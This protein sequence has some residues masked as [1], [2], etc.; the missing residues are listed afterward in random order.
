MIAT[1]YVTWPASTP[2]ASPLPYGSKLSAL[3]TLFVLTL[4]QYGRGRRLVVIAVL[5]AIPAIVAG[6]IRYSNH[7]RNTAPLEMGLM[8]TLIPHI[9]APL[10]ALLYAAGMIGDEVE[11][12][13]LTY[14]LI[15][16]LPKW[17]IYVTKLLA[18]LL[19]AIV[20]TAVFTTLTYVV[21][22][23][24][25][26]R[27]GADGLVLR[28]LK[29]SGLLALTLVAYAAIFGCLSL[30]TRW[31]LVVGVAYLVLFEG[32]LANFDF[33]IRKLT[34]MYYFRVLAERWLSW[35]VEEW[36]I[37]LQ[38]AP[39]TWVCVATLLGAGLVFTVI[40]MF[41]FTTREFRVKTPEGS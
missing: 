21:L 8:L 39:A 15:R 30:F 33:A 1:P 4:R 25:D 29:L 23:W 31:T 9:F 16:P 6:L 14:L 18:T 35:N 3:G 19:L 11:D 5:F 2:A 22:G 26:W 41:V 34:V 27:V 12:Q 32:V 40:A 7:D 17:A 36:S 20:L 28:A 38:K 24:G 37:D 10:T 13:T